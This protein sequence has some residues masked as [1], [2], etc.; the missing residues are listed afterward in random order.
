MQLHAEPRTE[1]QHRQFLNIMHESM[2][3]KQHVQLFMWLQG[4]LQNLLPHD[5]LLLAYGDL[6]NRKLH[7]EVISSAGRLRG[8]APAHSDVEALIG[9]LFERWQQ[10]GRNVCS[11]EI[12]SGITLDSASQS[13]LH[14]TLRSMRSIMVQGI[15]DERAGIDVLY[16][17]LRR[18]DGFSNEDRHMFDILLPH[19]DYAAR[20]VT[21]SSEP[22]GKPLKGATEINI[23][24][25]RENEIL[26]WVGNGK[27]NY[28]IGMILGISQFTVKNHL[29]RIF[30]KIDVSNR[31][32]AISRIEEMHR[33]LQ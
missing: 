28:E 14:Q 9:A 21:D 3:I 16:V 12:P 33:Q 17:L 10:Y 7:Y 1:P 27:T 5:A 19:I 32:Q 24:S 31:A 29:Q 6:P 11:L 18:W 2:Q 4:N 22:A 30:R 20:R 15:R 25:D 8:D 13:K 26:H 23:L